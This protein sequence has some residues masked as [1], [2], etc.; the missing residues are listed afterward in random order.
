[1]W[2]G[3]VP[4]L[5]VLICRGAASRVPG[6]SFLVPPCTGLIAWPL[7]GE[8]FGPVALVGMA[9][10]AVGGGCRCERGRPGSRRAEEDVAEPVAVHVDAFGFE[11][12]DRLED[13]V[14]RVRRRRRFGRDEAHAVL[15]DRGERAA[16]FVSSSPN[17]SSGTGFSPE[18]RRSDRR[19]RVP[20]YWRS[21]R[22]IL[23]YVNRSVS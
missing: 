16:R 5:Y 6:L 4:L 21:L 19:G 23:Q 8:R 22:C 15:V 11:R 12:G 20:H 17:N 10:T 18:R 1:M 7:S 3:A 9:V 13:V 14:V 2:L